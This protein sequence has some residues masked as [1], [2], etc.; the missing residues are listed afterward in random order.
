MTAVQ[1]YWMAL[2]ATS[3]APAPPPPGP[4][5]VL[6]EDFEGGIGD[7]VQVA[8]G[9]FFSTPSADYGLGLYAAAITSAGA[10]DHRTKVYLPSGADVAHF[11]IRGKLVAGTGTDDAP[12]FALSAVDG[13]TAFYVGLSREQYYDYAQRPRLG[14]GGDAVYA[15]TERLP[16]G[17][18][19]WFDIF[20]VSGAG[21]S[22]WSITRCDDDSVWASGNFASDHGTAKEVSKATIYAEASAGLSSKAGYFDDLY[23]Y[24]P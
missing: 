8:G 24:G 22:T 17:V 4:S 23:C 12:S 3:A 11:R 2:G 14:L 10:L 9:G 15:G 20:V 5:L 6:S 18:W 1:Q 13:S 7:W 21:N 19:Y 16:A